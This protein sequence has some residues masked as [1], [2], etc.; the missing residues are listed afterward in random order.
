MHWR[1]TDE[2]NLLSAC[3]GL[4]LAE[5]PVQ[6]LL[7]SSFMSF[8]VAIAEGICYTL[9]TLLYNNYILY[10]IQYVNNLF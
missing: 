3:T 1:L 10:V 7:F 6:A 9:Y 5:A 2:D 4:I 8:S